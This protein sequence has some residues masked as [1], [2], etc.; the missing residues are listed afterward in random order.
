M[1]KLIC[2]LIDVGGKELVLL[3]EADY[4]RTALH[5]FCYETRTHRTDFE[6]IK[7]MIEIGGIELLL[8]RCRDGLLPI[9][10]SDV[11]TFQC[12]L[13]FGLQYK[14]NGEYGVGGLFRCNDIEEDGHHDIFPEDWRSFVKERLLDSIHLIQQVPLLQA[15]I[16]SKAP[17]YV[18][19]DIINEVG[20]AFVVRE[21]S[22]GHNPVRFAIEHNMS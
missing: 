13:Q 1:N 10:S 18:L 2:N 4:H 7:K 5:I 19:H 20:E 9:H 21:D 15:A 8:S 14:V 22:L 16:A 3:K 17:L 6:V 12:L 11:T